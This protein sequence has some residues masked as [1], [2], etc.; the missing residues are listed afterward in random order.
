VEIN[1][2]DYRVEIFKDR[3]KQA[4]IM[5]RQEFLVSKKSRGGAEIQQGINLLT[6][7]NCNKQAAGLKQAEAPQ[8]QR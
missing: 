3:K 7:P 1:T 8:I 2:S 5:E 4:F 6:D